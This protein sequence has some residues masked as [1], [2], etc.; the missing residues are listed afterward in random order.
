[1]PRVCRNGEGG[2]AGHVDSHPAGHH[3]QTDSTK[4]VEALVYLHIRILTV[5]FTHITLFL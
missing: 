2:P 5:E 1:M 4:W 3:L